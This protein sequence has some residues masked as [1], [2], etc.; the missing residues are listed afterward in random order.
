[1]EHNVLNHSLG[2]SMSWLGISCCLLFGLLVHTAVSCGCRTAK[3]V[4]AAPDDSVARM[5]G[6][7]PKNAEVIYLNED[8]A[9]TEGRGFEVYKAANA[10]GS[11]VRCVECKHS[12][13]TNYYSLHSPNGNLRLLAT[14][15]SEMGDI[16]G[17]LV[18]YD[19]KGRVARLT[20]L[21]ELGQKG[22][23]ALG[24]GELKNVCRVFR[25]WILRPSGSACSYIV[26]RDSSGAITK[27]GGKRVPADYKARVF[28]REWAPSAFWTS[29]IS[30]GCMGIFVLHEYQGDRSGSYVNYLYEGD[31]LIAE[32]AC[33]K[34]TFIKARTYNE[35]GAMVKQYDDRNVNIYDVTFADFDMQTV[36]YK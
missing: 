21:N 25:E 17:I 18:D 32:L 1:M 7:D 34:G 9:Y 26:E 3:C 10:D 33:W 11:V 27:V 29:D 14:S 8:S 20:R 4:S 31:R 22:Y 6:N 5:W 16:V 12:P 19:A 15:Y 28:I 35:H 23:D 24:N 2:S 36:W 13:Y 30:G